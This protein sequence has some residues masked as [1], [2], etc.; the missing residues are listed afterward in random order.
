M[1]KTEHQEAKNKVSIEDA[2]SCK[3]KITIEIPE[4]SVQKATDSQYETLRREAVVPGFRKGRA[5]RRL[6]EK[7]FGKETSQQVKLSLLAEASDSAIQEKDL[8]VLR[9]PDIDYENIELPE[10]GSLKF[11]FEVEVKPE[12]EL[13]ELEGIPVDK[14]K[15]EVTKDQVETEIEKARKWSGLWAPKEGQKAEKEDQLIADA[16]LRTEDQEQKLDNIEI[17]VRQNGYVGP[18]PVQNLDEMLTGAEVGDSKQSTVAVPKTFFNEEYRGKKVEV[19]IKIKEIKFLKPAPIDENFLKRFGVEAEDELREKVR[20]SLRNRLEQQTRNQAKDQI[21]QYLL[22]NTELDLPMD[23]VADQTGAILQRQYANLLR[24]GLP[25][26]QIEENMEQLRA[27]SEE[28]AKKQMKTFFIIDKVAEQLN[29]EVTEEEINGQIAQIAMQRGQRP[30][31]LREQMAQNGSLSQFTLQVREDKCIA[32]LLESAKITETKPKKE[33]KKTKSKTE[34]KSKKT[35]KKR[36]KKKK[37]NEKSKKKK[38][39]NKKQ[40]NN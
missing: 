24:Q 18:I 26:E 1:G 25:R 8:D 40:D 10:K 12:F 36:S 28:Q 5:P 22:D 39:K 16:F 23:I 15:L 14:P 30:E 13:P 6:L 29:V 35:K 11:D 2:G 17:Y 38:T 34:S 32:K 7:R 27:G 31:R 3:K 37:Q 9:E 20:E 33:N 19:S 4:E 21:Q